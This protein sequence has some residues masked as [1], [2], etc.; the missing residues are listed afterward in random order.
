LFLDDRA[1]DG[2]F[3]GAAEID[4]IFIKTDH[5]SDDG[6]KDVHNSE[7]QLVLREFLEGYPHR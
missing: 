1:L 5:N 3:D 7:R 6:A 4:R 2:S